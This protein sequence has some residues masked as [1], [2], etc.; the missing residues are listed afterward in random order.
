MSAWVLV[1]CLVNLRAEFNAVSPDR[2]KGSDG[3]IGDSNHT[4]SSDHTPDEDSDVL[5]DHDADSKNEVHALDIDST[6]PWPWSFET[7]IKQIIASEKLKWLDPND[8][9]RLNYVI[10]NRKIYDKDNDF[11]PVNYTGSDP[12]TGHAHFSSRYET[13]CESD[14]RPWG[15]KEDEVTKA[16]FTAWMT[17]WA[18]SAAG[19]EALGKAVLQL[20]GLIPNGDPATNASNPEVSLAT[21]A[22]RATVGTALGYQ[23]RD[24]LDVQATAISTLTSKVDALAAVLGAKK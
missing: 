4:S 13:A 10:F 22:N 12:H 20:D 7:R 18:N 19:K 5:R 23:N 16:E 17:E 15:V 3:S 2:D 6:G 14:Q 24:R 8:K 11:A 1:P 9:C 21:A